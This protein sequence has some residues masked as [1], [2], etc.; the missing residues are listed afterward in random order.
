MDSFTSSEFKTSKEC[1]SYLVRLARRLARRKEIPIRGGHW[2]E[3]Q[4]QFPVTPREV[5]KGGF[6]T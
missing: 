1:I 3:S 4:I 2:I 6:T 5:M